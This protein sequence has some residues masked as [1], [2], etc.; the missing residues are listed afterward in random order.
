MLVEGLGLSA[1]PAAT[2]PAP[3]VTASSVAASTGSE[4]LAVIGMACRFPQADNP[5]ALWRILSEGIDTIS[6]VPPSRWDAD[7]LYDPDITAPGKMVSRWGGFIDGV[8]QFDARFFGISP[9][10]AEDMDPA[11]RI[12]LEVA[13]QALE[14]A[15][16]SAASAH[17]N[18]TGVYI[19]MSNYNDYA[20]LKRLA[21]EPTRVHAHHGTGNA[22]SI[23]AGRLAYFLGAQ[24][25]AMTVDTACSSSLVALHLA[26]Q[27]LRHGE[28]NMALVG[29]VNLILSPEQSLA[30]SKSGMLSPDGRCKTF[31]ARANG[32]VRSEGCGVIV[33]KRL[34]DA[35]RDR[36]RILGLVA[37]TAVNQDGRSSGLTAPNGQAQQELMRAAL[38]AAHMS[39]ADVGY[40]EAHGTGTP[41][42]DPIEVEAIGAVYGR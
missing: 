29:G 15:G 10:E 30:F 23:A 27:S 12:L 19:G 28:S 8:D 41:L 5:K 37:G 17:K 16:Q 33:L 39:P 36:D 34:S 4:P 20:T 31:D 13:W 21:G 35:L 24:G 26:A 9:K 1:Q 11:Q 7:A 25:P 2:A 38:A 32:Y 14:S 6:E 42:G 22:M 18:R 3:E 40:V